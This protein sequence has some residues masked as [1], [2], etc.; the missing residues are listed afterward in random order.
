MER[1]KHPMRT[2]WFAPVFYAICASRPDILVHKFIHMMKFRTFLSVAV[3]ALSSISF[4][5]E[6]KAPAPRDIVRDQNASSPAKTALSVG[7]KKPRDRA[8]AYYHYALAHS[9]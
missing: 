6:P 8:A 3:L 4:A 2:D 5:Q 1:E 7:E 9:Y